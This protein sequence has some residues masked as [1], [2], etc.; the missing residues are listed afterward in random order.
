MKKQV[1]HELDSR[2]HMTKFNNYSQSTMCIHGVKHYEGNR[3]K[4]NGLYP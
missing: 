4:I 3:E 1:L 2:Y